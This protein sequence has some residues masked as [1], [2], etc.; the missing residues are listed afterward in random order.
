MKTYL[1]L[2]LAFSLSPSAAHAFGKKPVQVP[3]PSPAPTPPGPAKPESTCPAAGTFQAVDMATP[4]DQRFLDVMKQLRVN[5]VIRYYDHT[6]ETIRGKT[7]KPAELDLLARNGFDAMVVFQHNNNQITSFTAARG[8]SDAIRSLELAGVNRQPAGSAIYFGVDG[9]WNSAADLAKVKTYFTQAAPRIRAG[10]YKV[11]AYGSG[12]VCT[13][14][15]KTG[16]ADLCWLA[17]ATGWPGYAAFKA[18]NQ[19]TMTQ[20]LPRNCGGKNVDFNTVNAAFRE[21][22]EWRP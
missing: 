1:L 17:N 19:W 5:T 12:M 20:T 14:L 9:G 2:L 4:V 22:G 7:L 15:L 13:E 3:S 18:T 10:G 16:L 11:G 6:N 8:N 21:I